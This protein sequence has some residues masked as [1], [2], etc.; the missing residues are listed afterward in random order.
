MS[1]LATN[2]D[3]KIYKEI[4]HHPTEELKNRLGAQIT[5]NEKSEKDKAPRLILLANSQSI[6]RPTRSNTPP[7]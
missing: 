6:R 4:K 3:T 2:K 7:R 5:R 1:H